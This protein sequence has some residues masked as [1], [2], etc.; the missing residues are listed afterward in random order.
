MRLR[1]AITV[2]ALLS[3][4]RAFAVIESYHFDNDVQRHR[5]QHFVEELRC[6]KCQNQNLAGSDAEIA[7]DLRREVHRMIMAGKSD[8]EITQ[9]MLQRYGDF[10]LYRPRV[11]TATAVLWFGPFALVACGALIWWRLSARRNA[12]PVDEELTADEEQRLADL[13]QDPQPKGDRQGD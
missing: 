10:V 3:I 2:L 6:P 4:S 13:M 5:Y 9:Y 12:A 1:L 7:Q 11:T 8:T